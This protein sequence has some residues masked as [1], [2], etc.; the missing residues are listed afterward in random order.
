[1]PACPD[2]LRVLDPESAAELSGLAEKVAAEY[3]SAAH[4]EFIRKA[5][6]LAERIPDDVHLELGPAD[7]SLGLFVLRGL[8][9]DDDAI[10]ATPAHWSTASE[11]ATASWDVLMMLLASAMGRP[12]GWAGQ[13]DG[14]L[15]PDIMPAPGHEQEQTGLSSTVLL[16]PHSEDAFHPQR[17]HLLMISCLRNHDQVGTHAACVRQVELD[18]ADRE[19]LSVPTLPI[20]PDDSYGEAQDFDVAAPLVTTLWDRADGMCVRFD[21]AYTPLHRASEAYRAAYH[22]LAGELERVT[23]SLRLDPG[24][25]LVIDNDAVVHGREPFQ[26]RYDGTDRWLK[27]VSVRVPGRSRPAAEAGEHGYG[28]QL[29]DP[30][31]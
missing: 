28:Q 19:L 31:A 6:E 8:E 13:Q 11:T 26:A 7:P 21:P 23:T 17:A 14:K 1:M 10:G 12:F 30:Y 9:I 22:R 3:G 16:S 20:L 24:D 5:P 2:P 29:V 15:V 4:P 27:R 25:V 18:D